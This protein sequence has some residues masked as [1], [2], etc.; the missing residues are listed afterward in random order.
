MSVGDART[1]AP[2]FIVPVGVP[3]S[4]HVA[5]KP[6]TSLGVTPPLASLSAK[7]M[8]AVMRATK[9]LSA[10]FW[11]GSLRTH[12]VDEIWRASLRF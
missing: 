10:P 6:A 5:T 2:R 1:G 4:S 8:G 11:T 7:R 3:A 12:G 9:M